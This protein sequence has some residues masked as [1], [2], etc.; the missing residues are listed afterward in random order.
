MESNELLWV[1]LLVGFSVIL[2]AVL[3][4]LVVTEYP[5]TLVGYRTPASLR[6]KEAWDFAQVYSANL[7]L[8]SSGITL[9]TQVTT[10]FIFPD[11]TSILITSGVLVV[12]IAIMMI[13]TELE[14]KKRFDKKGNPKS[15]NIIR[16]N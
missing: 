16:G 10:Y 11:E 4:K 1:H 9:L 2:P 5:N 15:K 3:M 7:M 14:L 6:S 13:M 8:W 12:G